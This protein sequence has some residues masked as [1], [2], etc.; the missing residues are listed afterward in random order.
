MVFG[1]QIELCLPN[2]QSGA[3]QQVNCFR[4]KF[5]Q[6]DPTLDLIQASQ[7]SLVIAVAFQ[8]S[9]ADKQGEKLSEMNGRSFDHLIDG[10]LE[11]QPIG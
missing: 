7:E 5:G 4:R 1:K 2:Q 8:E 11:S 9:L 6:F 3:G 10:L